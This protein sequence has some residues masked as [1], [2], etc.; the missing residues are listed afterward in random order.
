MRAGRCVTKVTVFPARSIPDNPTMRMCKRFCAALTV[1]FVV[2]AATARAQTYESVGTRAQGMGG[3]FVAV[4]DDAT[5]GWWNP[6]GLAAGAYFNVVVEKG[7]VSQ[8]G[9]PG[10][11]APAAR[12]GSRGFSAAFPGLGLGYYRL[13]VSQIAPLAT[14][15]AQ[16]GT[17]Q[18][19]PGGVTGRV[20]S[21]SLAQWGATVGQSI[22]KHLVI[23]S[24]LKLLRGGVAA[25]AVDGS[26]DALDAADEL[27][28][29]RRTRADMDLGAMVKLGRLQI[30]ASVRNLTRPQFGQGADTMTLVR[31]ARAGAAVSTKAFGPADALVI[32][33]DADMTPTPTRFGD[34]RHAAAGGELWLLRRRLGLRGGVTSNTVGDRRAATSTG[35]SVAPAKG[36]FLEASRTA[37]ADDSLAGWSTTLRLTF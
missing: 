2:C 6:A 21:L 20:V 36:F 25:A 22:G 19:D 30:G 14:T 27:N 37:G 15:G 23:G 34:V 33:A 35:I 8:P 9:T 11:L 24:T 16:D 12:T 5:A 4:A 10:P 29:D 1:L 28:V 7:Q 3:A 18:Q 31:Q 17:R 26:S 13:R 32:A